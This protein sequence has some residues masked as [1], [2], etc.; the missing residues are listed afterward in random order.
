[1]DSKPLMPAFKAKGHYVRL[2]G[3]VW[4]AGRAA[5]LSAV[6]KAVPV[7]CDPSGDQL[8]HLELP[9]PEEGSPRLPTFGA[10]D[11]EALALRLST[12]VAASTTSAG[13]MPP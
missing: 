2:C 6:L 4:T 7:R 11:S 12:S 8:E 3:S 10:K 1:L 5:L 13:V 9:A